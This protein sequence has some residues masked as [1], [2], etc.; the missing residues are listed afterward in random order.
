MRRGFKNSEGRVIVTRLVSVIRENRAWLSEIDGA[1][2]DGDHG[3]NMSKGFTMAGER[4]PEEADLTTALKTLGRTLLMEIGGSMGPLYGQFFKGMARATEGR[5]EIDAAVF[6]AM[7]R[8]AYAEI[9]KLG[10][11]KVGDKTLVDVLDP[12]LAAFDQ[13]L[14]EGA[15]FPAAL[16]GMCAAAERG[17]IPPGSSSP[18]SAAPRG[19][20][21]VPGERWMP[22]P[23]PVT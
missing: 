12:A 21:N 9:H 7:V 3:I 20:G 10:E 22:V 4:L 2:G 15:D 17:G 14:G 23:L 16:N 19:W 11:A 6:G 5:E 8:E 18:G 1:I 13:A